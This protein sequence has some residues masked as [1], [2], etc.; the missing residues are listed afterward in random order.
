MAIPLL[1]ESGDLTMTERV[2]LAALRQQPGFPVLE[3]LFME[4]IKRVTEEMQKLKPDDERYEQKLKNAHLKLR[5]R[6]EFSFLILQS[7]DWQSQVV[8]GQEEKEQTSKPELNRIV[9]GLN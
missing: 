9:K 5:E 8:A 7:I 6:T 2:S 1:M 3:K 4:A